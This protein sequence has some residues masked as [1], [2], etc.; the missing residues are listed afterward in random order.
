MI[1]AYRSGKNRITNKV[2][3]KL[4]AAEKDA[5][6][7]YAEPVQNAG[8]SRYPKEIQSSLIAGEDISRQYQTSMRMIPVVGWAHAGDAASYEE[9]PD[10]WKEKIAT[11]CRDQKA[12]GVRLEGDSMEPKFS[13][14]DI[15]ILQPSEQAH[16]GSLVVARF[17]DDGVIF[18]RLEMTGKTITLV[19]LNPRYQATQH[20]PEEFAWIYPIWG[21]ITH[22]WRK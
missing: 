20:K 22:L 17:K 5:G 10:A 7:E 1:F 15:L 16:S 9:I 13:E 14:G 12:F 4:E 3:L 11:E 6:I 8:S 21:R 18:R 2:W 19:P